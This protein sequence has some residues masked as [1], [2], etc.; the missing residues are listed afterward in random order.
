MLSLTIAISEG[1]ATFSGNI[2]DEPKGIL[3]GPLTILLTIFGGHIGLIDYLISEKL[4]C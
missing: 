1:L 4:D 2:G 3:S